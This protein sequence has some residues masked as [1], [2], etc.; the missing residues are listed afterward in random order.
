M[1][2]QHDKQF[3]PEAVQYNFDHKKLGVL[4]W[5]DSFARLMIHY[6]IGT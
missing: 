4:E 6:K 1:T 3:Q 2:K 5:T